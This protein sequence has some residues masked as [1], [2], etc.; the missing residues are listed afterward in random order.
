MGALKQGC[1]QL[2]PRRLSSAI[3][4]DALI[5]ILSLQIALEEILLLMLKIDHN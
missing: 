4:K 2:L 5:F 1:P 3:P